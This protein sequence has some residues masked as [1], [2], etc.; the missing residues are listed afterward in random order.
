MTNLFEDIQNTVFS[1]LIT[2]L[3]NPTDYYN[4][5]TKSIIVLLVLIGLLKLSK[6]GLNKT[7][8]D[9]IKKRRYSK[10]LTNFFLFLM[11][12]SVSIIW[13]TALNSLVILMMMLGLFF[14]VLIRG[15]LDNVI[16]WYFIRKRHYFKINQ[17]IEINDRIGKVL[18][19]SL[20]YFELAEIKNWLSS[21]SYTGR[22]IKIPNK[23]IFSY[24][25]F[26]YSDI[27]E[28]IRQELNFKIQHESDWKLAKEIILRHVNDY[29]E[30]SSIVNNN[31]AFYKELKVDTV[32]S[33]NLS[34]DE[35]GI[36]LSCQFM[37]N[38]R[39]ARKIKSQLSELILEDF[40]Q[41]KAIEFAVFDI[42][43]VD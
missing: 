7:T 35:S 42:R 27:D 10:R 11:I 34:V 4:H 39:E 28:T 33:I 32:P 20:F 31:K 41:S 17:R 6:Y 19:I 16:G 23:E 30:N 26:N 22:T 25:L 18:G 21:E 13:I 2:T 3:K 9:P 36:T 40:N 1:D 37:V 8:M 5:L 24:E 15:T 12:F 43:Q 29:Y 38:Y 14:M